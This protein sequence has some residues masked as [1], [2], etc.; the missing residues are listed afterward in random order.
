MNSFMQTNE[1]LIISEQLSGKICPTLTTQEA[2]IVLASRG[3]KIKDIK[4]KEIA[5][6]I[7]D[8]VGA[9]FVVLN[10]QKMLPED[11]LILEQQVVGDI[12]RDF[13]NLSLEDIKEAFH[14]GVRGQF[15]SK[16]EDV[17]F[18]SVATIYSW[19]RSYKEGMRREAMKKQIEFLNKKEKETKEL[20][21]QEK[22]EKAKEFLKYCIQAFEEYKTSKSIYDPVNAIYYALEGAGVIRFTK[23]RKDKI[24]AQAIEHLK[25][26]EDK[27]FRVLLER[28]AKEA[29]TRAK[30]LAAQMALKIFFDELIEME[31]E[32]KDLIEIK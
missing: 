26:T 8:L 22:E 28:G 24:Y 21:D 4:K 29:K 12:T 2:S 10:Q 19:L 3:A 18:I 13:Q 6:V 7:T 25:I 15:K 16:P 23:E 27:S 9:S 5:N 20:T 32:L 14:L 1:S 30:V 31:M 17:V 11:R